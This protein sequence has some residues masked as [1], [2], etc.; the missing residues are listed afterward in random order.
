MESSLLEGEKQAKPVK[1]T[2]EE[3]ET[4]HPGDVYK[5]QDHPFGHGRIEYVSGFGVS[6]VIILMGIEL[7]KT[8]LLYT[9]KE[10]IETLQERLTG[11]Y[12]AETI[13]DPDTGEVVVKANHMCTPKRAAAVDVYKRQHRYFRS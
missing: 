4:T 12:I 11:R 8:C 10:T 9:S 7:F 1:I 5:R 3:S 6:M 2:R 13:T